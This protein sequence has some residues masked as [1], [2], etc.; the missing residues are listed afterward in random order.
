MTNEKAF[1]DVVLC[2][3]IS[4]VNKQHCYDQ[5]C[6]MAE[7]E[8]KRLGIFNVGEMLFK[9]AEVLGI[10][11]RD[12]KIL[13]AP[14]VQLQALRAAVFEEILSSLKKDQINICLR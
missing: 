5:V 10:K 11:F 4:G 3:G 6:K 2:T 12:D 7:S 8:G 1:P 14:E 9:K 13:D